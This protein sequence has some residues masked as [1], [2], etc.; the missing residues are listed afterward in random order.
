LTDRESFENLEHWLKE[1]RDN[2]DE[3]C[4]IALV[5]NKIDLC[6]ADPFER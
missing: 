5:A 6:T 4:Q 3:N 1:L 2:C